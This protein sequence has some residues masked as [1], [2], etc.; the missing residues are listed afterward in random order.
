LDFN[1]LA[2]VKGEIIY[3][4]FKSKERTSF[5][6]LS[7]LKKERIRQKKIRIKIENLRIYLIMYELKI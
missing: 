3:K 1:K 7:S 2:L 4:R 5:K 6:L